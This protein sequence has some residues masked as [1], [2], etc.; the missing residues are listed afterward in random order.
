ML[1]GQTIIHEFPKYHIKV[2]A[3][4]DIIMKKEKVNK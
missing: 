1:P 2:W 3:T 4:L